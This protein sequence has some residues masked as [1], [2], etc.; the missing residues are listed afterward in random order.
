[1]A[2]CFYRKPK[3]ISKSLFLILCI[4]KAND[5][6]LAP[7]RSAC[8]PAGACIHSN[9]AYKAE[10]GRSVRQTPLAATAKPSRLASADCS[11]PEVRVWTNNKPH[12][13]EEAETPVYLFCLADRRALFSGQAA[14]PYSAPL[15]S[16]V[17]HVDLDERTIAAL[18][19]LEAANIVDGALHQPNAPPSAGSFWLARFESVQHRPPEGAYQTALEVLANWSA[20]DVRD[21]MRAEGWLSEDDQ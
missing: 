4:S 9:V 2:W 5:P 11:L 7:R 13:G 19:E 18:L 6:W 17:T 16:M 21:R 8:T 1:M 14:A 15:P 10:S 12:F 3:T 20:D